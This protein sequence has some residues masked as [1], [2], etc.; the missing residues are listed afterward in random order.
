MAL[1]AIDDDGVHFLLT[2]TASNSV[3]VPSD[4]CPEILAFASIE[5]KKVTYMSLH[6]F[7]DYNS[8]WLGTASLKDI[9]EAESSVD[10]V[11]DSEYDLTHNSCAHYAQAI[12][13]K[14]KF[15]ETHDLADFLIEN[16]LHNDGLLALAHQ[17]VAVGGLRVLSKFKSDEDLFKKYIK[18]TVNSQLNIK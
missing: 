9:I 13:R 3:S 7:G 12:W 17:K 16:L 18:E 5:S 10:P 4:K 2:A 11:D 1:K 8:H 14:L 15:E 6:G